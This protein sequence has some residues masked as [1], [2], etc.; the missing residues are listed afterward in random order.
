MKKVNIAGTY[1]YWR[2]DWVISKRV[3]DPV[4]VVVSGAVSLFVSNRIEAPERGWLALR[5]I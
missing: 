5:S 3:W 1:N 4:W 2:R